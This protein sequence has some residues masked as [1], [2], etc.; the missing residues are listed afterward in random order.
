MARCKAPWRCPRCSTSRSLEFQAAH[1]VSTRTCL[2]PTPPSS[3]QIPCSS[4]LHDPLPGFLRRPLH[5]TLHLTKATPT[6]SPHDALQRHELVK[7]H[8]G[9]GGKPRV[10]NRCGGSFS[11]AQNGPPDLRFPY[12]PGGASTS[13]RPTAQGSRPGSAAG[14]GHG[15]LPGSVEAGTLAGAC[16]GSMWPG[17][18]TTKPDVVVPGCC[19]TTCPR[20][21][22]ANSDLPTPEGLN[23]QR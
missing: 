18:R 15:T 6:L 16:R 23:A 22:R 1:R 7:T 8:D 10:R 4:P 20:Q 14:H 12:Q 21:G 13:I 9:A 11:V 19:S 5:P 17:A 2:V 3:G